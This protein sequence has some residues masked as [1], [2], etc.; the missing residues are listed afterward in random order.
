MDVLLNPEQLMSVALVSTSMQ[1]T[2]SILTT[3]LMVPHEHASYFESVGADSVFKALADKIKAPND[4]GSR[5]TYSQM[6][7]SAAKHIKVISTSEDL[8]S[9]FAAMLKS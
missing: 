7:C 3:F 5:T 6:F 9:K 4:A 2:V 8:I 1:F